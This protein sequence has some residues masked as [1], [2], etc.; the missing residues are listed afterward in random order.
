MKSYPLDDASEVCSL[1][2][3]EVRLEQFRNISTETPPLLA[4]VSIAS[5]VASAE[6]PENIASKL[7]PASV[8]KL[9]SEVNA[10]QPSKHCCMVVQSVRSV[11]LHDVNAVQL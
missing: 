8:A 4:V 2:F 10:E 7:V 11:K 6:H 9:P 1:A 5:I 3:G